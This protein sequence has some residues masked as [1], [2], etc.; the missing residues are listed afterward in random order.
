M[1]DETDIAF[2][3]YLQGYEAGRDAIKAERDRYKA[4]RDNFEIEVNRLNAI[5]ESFGQLVV[6]YDSDLK[7]HERLSNSALYLIS[8]TP[9]ENNFFSFEQELAFKALKKLLEQ[10]EK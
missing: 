3:A 2:I 7:Y 5:C 10:R 8:L 6:R 4:E 9:I 1:N